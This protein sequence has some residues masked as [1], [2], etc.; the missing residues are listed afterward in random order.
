MF[1]RTRVAVHW[2][3]GRVWRPSTE[4]EAQLRRLC[5]G[6]REIDAAFQARSGCAFLCNFEALR[7]VC[8]FQFL[9]SGAVFSGPLYPD[10][11]RASLAC[12]PLSGHQTRSVIGYRTVMGGMYVR[13]CYARGKLP[14]ACQGVS[15]DALA[16]SPAPHTQ[17]SLVEHLDPLYSSLT[18][19]DG[20]PLDACVVDASRSQWQRCECGKVA[21]LTRISTW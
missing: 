19:H 6:D 18:S 11:W 2:R 3:S 12:S 17:Q 14:R 4:R 20:Q 10:A 7:A 1:A 9:Q 16:A 8:V 21:I 13:P 15:A 5:S